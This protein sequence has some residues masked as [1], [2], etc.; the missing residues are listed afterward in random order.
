MAELHLALVAP[1]VPAFAP[2]PFST[3]DQRT[4]YQT[5]R[6][7]AGRCL[8][9]LRSTSRSL[10]PDAAA[11]AARVLAREDHTPHRLGALLG[12]GLPAPRTRHLGA[13]DLGKVL[14]TSN[15]FLFV[16]LEGPRSSP[17]AERRRKGS[18]LRDAASMLR[19]FHEAA[20]SALLDP[21]R[22]R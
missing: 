19:S 10:P 18:P 6:N 7:L 5:M 1:E 22:V 4:L 3:S 13:L 15:D 8:R 20:Y 21:A 16:D 2:E 14:Y 12:H 11:L 17:V 9:E